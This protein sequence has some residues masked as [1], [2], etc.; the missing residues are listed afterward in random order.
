MSVTESRIAQSEKYMHVRYNLLEFDTLHK[1]GLFDKKLFQVPSEAHLHIQIKYGKI[2]Q[3]MF[4]KL[5]K[6]TN[7]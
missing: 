6:Q 1:M 5:S 3:R 7:M 4:L 2:L